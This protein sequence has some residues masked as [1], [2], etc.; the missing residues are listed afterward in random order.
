MKKTLLIISLT[1]FTL[2]I[3]NAQKK[4]NFGVKGGVNFSN[5][6]SDY[7]TERDNKTEFNLGLVAEIPIVNKFSIQTEILYSGQGTKAKVELLGGPSLVEY[8]LEYLQ[9]PILAKIYLSQNLSIEVG[10]SLNFLVKDEEI[11]K[12]T[13]IK[14]VGCNFEFSG[15]LGI[16]Y[17]VKGGFFGSLRYI[18]G[19]TVALDRELMDEDAKNRVFQLGIGYM[20]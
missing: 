18:N 8:N 10:P 4:I 11:Y 20:F 2:T 17:K 14:N 1:F 19:F 13:T 15:V 7:F 9:V 5:M 12:Y 16:S 6:T 3:V